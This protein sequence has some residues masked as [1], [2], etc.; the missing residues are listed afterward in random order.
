MFN[1]GHLGHYSS[2]SHNFWTNIL[3]FYSLLNINSKNLCIFA[4]S[5]TYIPDIQLEDWAQKSKYKK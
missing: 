2:L 3:F 1:I 4:V 5:S